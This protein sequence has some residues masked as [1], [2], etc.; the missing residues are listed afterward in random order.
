[1]NI[2]ARCFLKLAKQEKLN[3][4]PTKPYLSLYYWSVFGKKLNLKSPRTYNE[5][6]QW[7]KI[8]DQKPIY[9][10]MVDKYLVKDY[11][12]NIIGS[13][14]IIPTLGAWEKAQDIDFDSLPDKFVLKTTHDSGGVKI[15]DKR[16]ANYD[17][18]ALITFFDK[19]LKRSLYSITREWP[20]KNV[21]PRVIAEQFLETQDDDGIKDYKIFCFN[22]IA[23]CFKIDF[24]R[25]ID[26]RANY[27]D[28]DN[29]LLDLGEVA[30]PPDV[31]RKVEIPT[32]IE[33]MKHLAE[34]LADESRFLRAD[35]YSVNGKV[36]FGE[37]TFYPASGFGK[38]IGDNSDLKL[39][40]W[41]KLPDSSGGVCISI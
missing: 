22:G 12:A 40:E 15:V 8:Y 25:F 3:W 24:D 17:E 11:V 39:G 27:Y 2:F 10:T 9:T 7:L 1:M 6:L 18:S 36:Y 32:S 23:K 13:E 21:K 4:M 30:C 26:H 16:S 38:L 29:N 34:T 5:K 33:L 31:N 28:E 19:R 37:L 41:I 14:Y 20:Y 35:F